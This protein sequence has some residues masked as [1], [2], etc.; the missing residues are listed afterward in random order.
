MLEDA[1]RATGGAPKPQVR[2]SKAFDIYVREIAYN[3]QFYKSP[4][5]RAS[6]EATFI[7]DRHGVLSRPGALAIFFLITR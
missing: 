6:W 3:A 7:G 2:V 4:A 5:Q 1:G